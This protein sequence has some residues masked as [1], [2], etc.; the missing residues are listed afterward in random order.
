MAALVTVAQ[1]VLGMVGQR[2]DKVAMG[3]PPQAVLVRP[4]RSAATQPT[5]VQTMAMLQMEIT[6][7]AWAALVAPRRVQIAR[8]VM[9]RPAVRAVRVAPVV[10]R[11]AE[12]AAMAVPVAAPPVAPVAPVEAH[13]AGPV[14]SLA[15]HPVVPAVVPAV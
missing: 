4:V 2:R 9:V 12:L 13:Q 6:R 5:E 11:Q 1:A 14:D 3:Q 8:R 7:P 10:W 15:A